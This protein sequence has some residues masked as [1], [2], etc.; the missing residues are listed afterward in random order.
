LASGQDPKPDSAPAPARPR[1]V[2]LV[3][4]GEKA[5]DDPRDPTLSEAGK[6]RAAALLRLLGET[7][8]THVWTS[9]FKRTK[10][11]ASGVA[12]RHGITPEVVPGKDAAGLTSRLREL[13]EGSISLV[14]GHSNTLPSVAKG[15]GAALSGLVNGT[16]LRD[17][18]YDRFVVITLAR[19]GDPCALLEMRYG[20]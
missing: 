18:E 3:R 17:D 4:H 10:D 11:F 20:A 1:T 8:V 16:D 9:E 12:A 7:K 5:A 14:C 19:K 6:L 13:S 2:I 15:L